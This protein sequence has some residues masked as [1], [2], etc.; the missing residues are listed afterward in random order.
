MKVFL[1]NPPADRI[2]LRDNYCCHSSKG[3]YVW[4][5]SDLVYVTG[6]LRQAHIQYKV[7]DA[8]AE[9]L[10][11]KAVRRRMAEFNP[12]ICIM[13]TGSA[14]FRQDLPLLHSWQ[15]DLEFDL[16]VMGN[17]PA[18]R[19]KEFLME[20]LYVKGIFHNFFSD[21]IVPFLQGQMKN[22]KSISHRN[23]D[24]SIHVGEINHW[25]ALPGGKHR[26]K[27]LLEVPPPDF[28]AFPMEAY[29][30]PLSMRTP[31]ATVIT[32]F[33]C[34]YTCKFCVASTL[35]WYNRSLKSLEAEFDDLAQAGVR[36]LF[37]MDSTF[38]VNSNR[39]MEVCELLIRKR[40]RFT[41]SCNIHSK[42]ISMGDFHIMRRAGCHTVQIGVET[43]NAETH[44]EFAPSKND[45]QIRRAIGLAKESGLRV[46]AY[47]IVGFPNE[48]KQM[49][50]RTIDYAIDLDPDFASFSTLMPD[51]GTA[52]GDMFAATT[53]VA[54]G[55]EQL[56]DYDNSA[57][58]MGE[59]FVL[60][61]KEREKLLSRAYSQFYLRPR[62]LAKYA[63]DYKN[64]QNY[65][66]NGVNLIKN[67]I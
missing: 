21:E 1:L 65:L 30:T 22:S 12:D 3:A 52:Y 10:D 16:Y 60:S 7:C 17:V 24:A 23:E 53:G 66:R 33:G 6:Y 18:F 55:S 43:A 34:P 40:Y 56:R 54:A 63:R 61:P 36:E 13:L 62:R 25:G 15:K 5:P 49:V 51:Y 2:V 35:N 11:A 39:L 28:A 9:N 37:F 57:K 59:N 67:Y 14:T 48:T 31:V 8:I 46:L 32:A 20:F 29:T 45:P 42:N 38:N 47:F 50:R 4:A 58:P 64:F 26:S 41:W 27:G 19:P 44:K